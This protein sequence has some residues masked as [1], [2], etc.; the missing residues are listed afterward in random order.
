MQRYRISDFVDDDIYVYKSAIDDKISEHT[1][2][3]IEI[4]YIISGSGQHFVNEACYHVEKGDLLFINF[5]Q[6]H[7]FYSYG[8]MSFINCLLKPEFISKELINSDN[9]LEILALSSFEDFSSK[10][11]K[12]ITKISFRGKKLIEVESIFDNMV[13]EVNERSI[14]Y[15]TALKGYM[16]VLL[17]KIFRE[18]WN[19]DDS[20]ILQH[21]NKITPDIL[22]YI[23]DKCF[24]KITL[25]ELARKCFYNPSYFSRIFKEYYGK[26]L[27]DFIHEKR[28]TEA[29]RLLKETELSIE[30]ISYSVGYREKKQF[31]KTFKEIMGVTPNKVRSSIKK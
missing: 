28:I 30:D 31:Y 12:L 13:I 6:T 20:G 19:E 1:H 25:N 17:T 5:N 16:H 23:E 18:M 7:S 26:S 24:E 15:N 22:K 9:A 14:G 2:E 4:V 29:V 3:F 11:G 10:V 27:T 8:G 21:V